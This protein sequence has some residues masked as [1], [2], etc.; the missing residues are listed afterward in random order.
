VTQDVVKNL[1]TQRE[2][3]VGKQPRT[4]LN[5]FD[6][7]PSTARSTGIAPHPV[8]PNLGASAVFPVIQKK[9]AAY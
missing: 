8:A 6:A 9:Q 2:P 7:Q 5:R 1:C 3:I 4:G